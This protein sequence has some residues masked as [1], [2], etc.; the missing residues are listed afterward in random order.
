MKVWPFG[1]ALRGV[2]SNRLKLRWLK[3][4]VV[5]V[6]EKAQVM[7]QVG[8]GKASVSEPLMTCR[9]KQ[10]TSK[11]G[12][13]NSPGMSLA[14]ARLLARRCPAWRRRESGLRLLHGTWEG[15]CRHRC[16]GA[17]EC[18]GGERERTA[19]REP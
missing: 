15:G 7:R 5:S 12:R 3:T 8:T 6:G 2:M 13:L 19:R 4:V 10:M 9:N 16:P 17:G 18:R 11:P 14:G 1:V